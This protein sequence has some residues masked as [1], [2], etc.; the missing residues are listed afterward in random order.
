MKKLLLALLL[1]V[2][3][4][5]A[6]FAGGP[7][8]QYVRIK[9]SYGECIIRLYNETPKHRDN[10]IKLVKKDFITARCSTE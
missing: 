10:F 5:S 1:T 4:I 3:T 8:N 7:K 9:T 6:V 2:F